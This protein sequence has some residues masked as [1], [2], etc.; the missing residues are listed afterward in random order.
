MCTCV[1]MHVCVR[2]C[3]CNLCVVIDGNSQ[4]SLWLGGYL[5]KE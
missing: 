2:V 5:Q 4:V 1:R 3:V